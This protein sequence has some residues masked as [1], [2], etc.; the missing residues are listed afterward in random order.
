[1]GSSEEQ[2]GGL[3]LGL[4]LS[5]PLDTATLGNMKDMESLHITRFLLAKIPKLPL[6]APAASCA[7]SGCPFKSNINHFRFDDIYLDMYGYSTRELK[8]A[9]D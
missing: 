4:C 7:R 6:D 1:M 9:F 8:F 2:M 5:W 3:R